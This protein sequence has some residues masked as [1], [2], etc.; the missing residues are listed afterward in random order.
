MM[1]DFFGTFIPKSPFQNKNKKLGRTF[2]ILCSI[3]VPSALNGTI[4][5]LR[6]LVPLSWE[7]RRRGSRGRE[8]E[9]RRKVMDG[10]GKY[11]RGLRIRREG[12]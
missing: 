7:K 12:M 10:D 9:E 5:I 8:V 6:S 11:G 3:K 1:W 4:F 2:S